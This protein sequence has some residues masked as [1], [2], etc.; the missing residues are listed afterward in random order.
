M[1]HCK[2][3][4]LTSCQLTERLTHHSGVSLPLNCTAWGTFLHYKLN[5]EVQSQHCIHPVV[6]LS[7][8]YRYY[9]LHVGF[10]FGTDH[11][12]HVHACL[13]CVSNWAIGTTS[14]LIV[15]SHGCNQSL[16]PKSKPMEANQGYTG[17]KTH[18]HKNDRMELTTC[19]RIVACT[20]I[21]VGWTSIN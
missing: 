4:L 1:F 20:N 9:P 2:L 7:I 11:Q 21:K 3:L 5:C 16:P 15:I 6:S 18:K 8:L 19:M 14:R 10:D 12:C 17:I 13:R